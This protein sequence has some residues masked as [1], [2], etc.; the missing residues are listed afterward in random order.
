M[1]SAG[2]DTAISGKALVNLLPLEAGE[3]ITSILLLPED[4]STW[5]QLELVFATRS[6]QH[7]PKLAHGF[8]EHQPQRKDRDEAR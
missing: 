5:A 4:D 3:V 1:A 2:G 8:R 6:W 7:P